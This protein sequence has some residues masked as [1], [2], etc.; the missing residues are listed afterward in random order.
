MLKWFKES[1][2][3]SKIE[4]S[5]LLF[6]TT[7]YRIAAYFDVDAS[8]V[9]TDVQLNQEATA[10]LDRIYLLHADMC[11]TGNLIKF[12]LDNDYPFDESKLALTGYLSTQ[13][14]DFT[15]NKNTMQYNGLKAAI[16]A[17]KSK[18]INFDLIEWHI[19]AKPYTRSVNKVLSTQYG[20]AIF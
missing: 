3:K 15:Q 8:R 9:F 11:I 12:M 17:Y 4:Y 20:T 19:E 18:K 1:L 10:I 6:E 13:L 16:Q 7:T 2:D 14:D 5:S